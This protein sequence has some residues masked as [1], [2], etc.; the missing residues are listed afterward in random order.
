LGCMVRRRWKEPAPSAVQTQAP[1]TKVSPRLK[2]TV[3]HEP[4]ESRGGKGVGSYAC[5]S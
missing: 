3:E 1:N 4:W 2:A 5:G